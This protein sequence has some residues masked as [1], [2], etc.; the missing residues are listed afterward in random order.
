M[1]CSRIEVFGPILHQ[2][3]SI[4]PRKV[5][6]RCF[7]YSKSPITSTLTMS[8][9]TSKVRLSNTAVMGAGTTEYHHLIKS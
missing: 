8:T 3:V 2:E 4:G 5:D 7:E 1:L 9:S 6:E